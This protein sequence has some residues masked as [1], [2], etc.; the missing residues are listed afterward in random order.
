MSKAKS[1]GIFTG[2]ITINLLCYFGYLY[3]D[4]TGNQPIN[5]RLSNV[6]NKYS[7]MNVSTSVQMVSTVL[8]PS[9]HPY[10]Q[11]IFKEIPRISSEKLP[12]ELTNEQYK[13]MIR[14]IKVF[15]QMLK[16][17]NV[18]WIIFH[19]TLIG[20]FVCHDIL[21]WDGDVDVLVE[22][23]SFSLLE[24]LQNNGTLRTSYGLTFMRLKYVCKVFFS[25]ES[26]I[27]NFTRPW[28]W[29]FIDM[30]MFAV[31]NSTF[32]SLDQKH[33]SH[34]F[35]VPFKDVFPLHARPFGPLWLPA[36]KNPWKMLSLAYE[37]D[38]KPMCQLGHWNHIKESSRHTIQDVECKSLSNSYPFVWRQ[39]RGN[40]SLETLKLANISLYSTL[41][42][43]P[44]YNNTNPFEWKF[45]E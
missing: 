41:I 27:G 40:M 29:P 17:L 26:N 36:P 5:I 13:S 35:S 4:H 44:Y 25:N 20:S 43:E 21:P 23:G 28:K 18:T 8:I 16:D 2:F 45:V 19:G 31:R 11:T 24:D 1:A 22:E 3:L 32:L 12:R 37:R 38:R 7:T 15:Q 10:L 33:R 42:D 6:P 34:N 30:Q 39:K 14:L 9:G